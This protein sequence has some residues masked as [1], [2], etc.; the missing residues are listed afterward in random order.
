MKI[1][2]I[3]IQRVNNYGSVLQSYATQMV[4]QRLGCEHVII[5]YMRPG[6]ATYRDFINYALGHSGIWN[7]NKL[8]RKL[9]KII[10]Y[11]SYRR[12]EYVFNSFLEENV[13]LTHQKYYCFDDLVS[14]PPEAD[15]YCTG[16]D[17]TWNCEYNNGVD[18]SYL[19]AFK[20]N[21][22]KISFSSSIGYDVLS[23]S[24]RDN[25]IPYLKKYQALSV[26]ES[27]AK[28]ELLRLGV[29]GVEHTLDPTLMLDI[30]DWEGFMVKNPFREKYL[31]IY[32]LNPSKSF[33]K[34]AEQIAKKKGLKVV[35]ICNLYDHCFRGGKTV[36][37]PEVSEWLTLIRNADLVVTDSFHGTAFSI[38]FNRQLYVYYPQKFSTRLQSLLE[39]FEMQNR[40]LHDGEPLP[41]LLDIDYNIIN[42]KLKVLRKKTMDYLKKAV[43]GY[44]ENVCCNDNI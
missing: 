30:D 29:C 17:Q 12:Q 32:Q 15:I 16:S 40:V 33:D 3:T 36:L 2:T 24:E 27:S 23:E 10:K 26:R 22:Y 25:F 42:E 43:G 37:I 19:L 13:R 9:Y 6:L 28:K 4:F 39:M 5:D 20:K 21:I 18:L 31:L 38:N 7:K 41:D 1:A 44:N 34:F 11:P 8:T 14:N 35:R